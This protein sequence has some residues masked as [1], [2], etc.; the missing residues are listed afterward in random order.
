MKAKRKFGRFTALLI[1]AMMLIPSNTGLF[2]FAEQER[3]TL[4]EHH[5]AH[6]AE[7]GYVKGESP[8]TYV[9]QECAEKVEVSDDKNK[10]ETVKKT[11]EEKKPQK[12]G[13]KSRVA[14]D[15]SGI[16]PE[17]KEKLARKACIRIKLMK[18]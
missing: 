4:C 6:T 8:C 14:G 12:V 7:C 16:S 18:I 5:P 17:V 3:D 13:R 10:E 1:A 9:C 11:D 15:A 2:A